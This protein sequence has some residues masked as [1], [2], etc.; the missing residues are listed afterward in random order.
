M[1]FSSLSVS[2]VFS[3]TSDAM[4]YD[5]QKLLAICGPQCGLTK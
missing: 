1:S 3:D 5:L 4:A 2:F